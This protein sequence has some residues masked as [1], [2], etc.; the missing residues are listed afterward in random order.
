[1]LKNPNHSLSFLL[2]HATISFQLIEIP[3]QL[4]TNE[5]IINTLRNLIDKQTLNLIDPNQYIL[6]TICGSLVIGMNIQKQNKRLYLKIIFIGEPIN[7]KLFSLPNG[8]YLG[9]FTP[10][11]IG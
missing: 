6:H 8:D 9:E 3:T 1:M 11:K 5:Q 4:P 10:N 2:G 7:V